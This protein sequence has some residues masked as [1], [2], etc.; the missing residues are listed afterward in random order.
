MAE[1]HS[2]L[3]RAEFRDL[4]EL[5]RGRFRA[6]AQAHENDGELPLA[7]LE[8]IHRLG[9]LHIAASREIGRAHV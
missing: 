6:W 5:A 8:D 7:N 9:L 2:I 1:P 4:D 3:Q